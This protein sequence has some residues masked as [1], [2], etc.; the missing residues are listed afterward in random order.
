M[1]PKVAKMRFLTQLDTLF[2]ELGAK[3]LRKLP[4]TRVNEYEK[5]DWKIKAVDAQRIW[6]SRNC[7]LI[8]ITAG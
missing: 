7:I 6:E 5:E 8:Y 1:I 2:K 4:T 3:N